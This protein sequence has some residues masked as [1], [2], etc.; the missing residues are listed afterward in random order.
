MM[1][2]Y[3]LQMATNGLSHS[4]SFDLAGGAEQAPVRR[5]L[6][7]ALDRVRTHEV[8]EEGGYEKP[9]LIEGRAA[10]LI[11][12]LASPPRGAGAR[13]R[14]VCCYAGCPSRTP[15]SPVSDTRATTMMPRRATRVWITDRAGDD[16]SGCRGRGRTVHLL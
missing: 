6:D 15:I 5:A 4:P 16:G 10:R 3:E 13:G 8:T 11:L 9:V 7:P 1:S 14:G 2:T 12:K